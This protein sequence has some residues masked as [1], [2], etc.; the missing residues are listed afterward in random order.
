M[1]IQNIV[2]KE[3]FQK[4]KHLVESSWLEH[5]PFAFWLINNLK[6][7][8]IVELGSF[9]GFSLFCFCQALKQ[10]GLVGSQIYAI[11]TWQG[12]DHTSYYGDDIFNNVTETASRD[13]ADTCKLVRSTFDNAL[14]EFDDNSIDLLHIDGLHTYEAVKHDFESW[15]PKLTKNA[16]ILFHDTNVFIKDFG[17]WKFWSEITQSYKG[18]N[19]LHGFGLGILS[20]NG[21]DD[22]KLTPFFTASE[23]E[24]NEIRNIYSTIG[25]KVQFE[26]EHECDSQKIRSLQHDAAMRKIMQDSLSWRITSPI[27]VVANM[28]NHGAYHINGFNLNGDED[29]SWFWKSVERGEW[30]PETF[31]VFN[32]FVKKRDHVCDLGG[33]IGPTVLYAAAKGAHVTTFEPDPTAFQYLQENVRLNRFKKVSCYNF[34]IATLNGVKKISL[35]YKSLGDSTSSLLNG[36]RDNKESAHVSCITWESACSKYQLPKFDFIKI[37]IEG[38]EFDVI[39]HME[40]YLQTNKPVIYLSTHAPYLAEEER[41]MKLKKIADILESWG[42]LETAAGIPLDIREL[43]S[44]NT[45]NNFRSFIIRPL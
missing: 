29:H 7:K 33:W 37:D 4:P 22:S 43:Y 3:S 13:Y 45:Q 26:W 40:S 28:L 32:R 35:F 17:V 39:P 23:Q 6:P 41:E 30:E 10:A 1:N 42:S 34:A 21:G 16:V 38:S 24:V 20:L 36:E 8:K 11:D 15:L 19:F 14:V 9:N 31:D 44:S 12:D 5:A 18:F 2:S 27:R 25:R